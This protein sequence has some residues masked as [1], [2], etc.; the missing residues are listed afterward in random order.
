MLFSMKSNWSCSPLPICRITAKAVEQ[1]RQE[2]SALPGSRLRMDLTLHI[3]CP[4]HCL[5]GF[6]NRTSTN[7]SFGWLF[8]RCVLCVCLSQ[9][10]RKRC[11]V[12]VWRG[13]MEGD[14]KSKKI[15]REEKDILNIFLLLDK[16]GS[17]THFRITFYQNAGIVCGDCKACVDD[18]RRFPIPGRLSAR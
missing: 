12:V 10:K 2:L 7:S 1:T 15:A 5:A 6:P 17:N 14:Y 18:K 11:C 3:P 4:A 9:K 13:E 16:C 8:I